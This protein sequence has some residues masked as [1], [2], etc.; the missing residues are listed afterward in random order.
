MKKKKSSI[1]K[2]SNLLSSGAH[3]SRSN[4]FFFLFF[5]FFLKEGRGGVGGSRRGL[6][7]I[8]TK[9]KEFAP[10][11]LFKRRLMCK[12]SDEEVEKLSLKKC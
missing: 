10:V 4:I 5:F 12:K 9:R 3:I 6:E 7:G 1:L 11:A 2:G 8:Y